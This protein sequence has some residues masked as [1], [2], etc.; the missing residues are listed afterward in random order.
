MAKQAPA[1]PR[2]G[3][4]TVDTVPTVQYLR[5]DIDAPPPTQ[6]AVI[7]PVPEADPVVGEHRQHLDVAAAWGVPAH[8]TV[9]YPFVAPMAVDEAVVGALTA[10]VAS[11]S[12]FDCSFRRT[13]WFEDDVLW[14]DP[15]PDEPFRR[16]T[17]AVWGAFPQHPPY[18]GAHD[19][20]IAHLTVAQRR[21]ADL[22]ALR[23]AEHAVRS[24]LPLTTTI[25]R[26]L[27][28]AGT[29]APRSWSVLAELP[30]GVRARSSSTVTG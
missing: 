26:L 8:V 30:L 12:A 21:P 29:Q 19:D 22:P 6:T 13:R 11:V 4:T 9:L 17:G 23:A 15:E 25:D 20:V 2:P 27:L 7:A 3:P 10:A 16:L 24:R 1:A 18:G 14:L 28:I 5:P